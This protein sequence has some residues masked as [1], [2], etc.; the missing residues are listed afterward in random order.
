MRIELQLDER[1]MLRLKWL[2][3]GI[4]VELSQGK[5]AES[6]HLFQNQTLHLDL[7]AG[8]L[9]LQDC[10]GKPAIIARLRVGDLRLC[11][12]QLRLT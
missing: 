8:R 12:L 10:Q 11:L 1:K 3:F 5:S 4:E 7:E 6:R 9:V 2:F